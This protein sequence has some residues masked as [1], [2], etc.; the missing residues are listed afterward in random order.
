MIKKHLLMS[1]EYFG[2][3]YALI[4]LKKHYSN[5]FKNISNSKNLKMQL[6]NAKTIKEILELLKH[7]GI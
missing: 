1:N 2:E 3:R 6:M 5:Y 4:S 7:P